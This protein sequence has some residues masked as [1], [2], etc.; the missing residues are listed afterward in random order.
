M[1]A[2]QEAN[3]GTVQPKGLFNLPNDM[4]LQIISEVARHEPGFMSPL[5]EKPPLAHATRIFNVQP[6]KRTLLDLQSLAISSS[7]LHH[8]PRIEFFCA[9]EAIL[10]ALSQCHAYFSRAICRVQE[11]VSLFNGALPIE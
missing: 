7:R 11:S 3:A 10:M 5:N 6:F 1:D 8:L 9:K 2:F 4:L